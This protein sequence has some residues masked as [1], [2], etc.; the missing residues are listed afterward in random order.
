MAAKTA[1]PGRSR[2]VSHLSPG[3]IVVYIILSLWAVGTIFP[4]AW[5]ILNS[6]KQNSYIMKNTFA[7]PSGRMF[8]LDNYKIALKSV[9]I[10][11]A[12]LN[13]FV[14][15]ITCTVATILLAGFAAYGMARYVFKGKNALYSLVIASMMFP[16]F[17]TIIPVFTMEFRWNI[18]NTDSIPLSQLSVILPQIAGNLSFAIIVLIGFIRSVPVD[19]EEAAYLEGYNVFQIF[20]QVVVFQIRPAIATVAIFT[21]LSSYNDLFIQMFFLRYRETYTITVLLNQI[22]SIAGTNYGMMFASIV[23]VVVPI[24]IVYMLLQKNIIKGLTAGALKG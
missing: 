21:F 24:L 11:T 3:K 19:L 7:I 18:V 6:F 15:S 1:R 2:G 16:I 13:S 22:T 10:A 12:Y 9:N 17:S 14:I 23:F 4:F 8:T 20:F 5:V